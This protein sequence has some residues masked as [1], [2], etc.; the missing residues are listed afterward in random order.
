MIFFSILGYM[1]G[2]QPETPLYTS[3]S[4]VFIN[5]DSIEKLATL[6]TFAKEPIVLEEVRGKLGLERSAGSLRSQMGVG[7]VEGTLITVISFVDSNPQLATDLANAATEAFMNQALEVLAFDGV[8]ILTRAEMNPYAEPIN[9]PSNR[10]T[11][12]AAFAGLAIGIGL[13]FLADSLDDSIRTQ[14]DVE[15]LMGLHVVGKVSRFRKRDIP[16]T[17]KRKPEPQIRGGISSHER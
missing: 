10:S 11:Y 5:A 9:P 2:S 17:N 6:K 1:Y 4:R 13:I 7:S 14:R 15:R 16:A 8:E 3:S 12:L